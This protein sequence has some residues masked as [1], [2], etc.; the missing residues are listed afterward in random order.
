MLLAKKAR[1]PLARVFGTFFFIG[2][3]R[4]TQDNQR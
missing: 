1:D 3:K 4:P 2:P